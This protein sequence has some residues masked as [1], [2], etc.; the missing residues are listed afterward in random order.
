M[1]ITVNGVNV[2]QAFVTDYGPDRT[3]NRFIVTEMSTGFQIGGGQPEKDAK[4]H[5]ENRIAFAGI[6]RF[7]KLVEDGVAKYGR[8]NG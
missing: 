1:T 7:G 2:C 6:E 3:I 8:A 4:K 5:A